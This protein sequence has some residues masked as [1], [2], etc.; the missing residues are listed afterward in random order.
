MDNAVTLVAIA[1]NEGRYLVEWIAYHLAIG[2]AR[3]VVYDNESTDGSAALL[4]HVALLDKRIEARAWTVEDLHASP[5]T[6][7]YNDALAR[8]ATPWV[9]C[10]D[11]DEFLVPFA[12]GSIGAF[13]DRVPAD[14]A[15]IHVNWKGF[16]SSG[17]TDP[18]Y[19][20]VTQT[21]TRTAHPGWGNNHHFK[22]LARTA[23]VTEAFI[24]DIETRSG[25][26]LLSDLEEFET[27]SRG[28]SSRIVHDGIQINHYQCKT[29]IEFIERMRRGDANYH[30]DHWLRARDASEARFT[31]LDHNS[32]E[33]LRIAVFADRHMAVHRT[34][35]RRLDGLRKALTVPVA[36]PFL[37]PRRA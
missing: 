27:A 3:I 26:R 34:L 30:P 5:Q 36:R 32:D 13:L 7:A 10:L 37:A 29:L 35:R 11:I 24:H 16:G 12:D 8:V 20:L 1:K 28:L 25:R 18:D 19:E 21:F 2:V 6:T 15:S 4:K 17:R 31:H 22:T 14:A 23:L 9:M 33:D